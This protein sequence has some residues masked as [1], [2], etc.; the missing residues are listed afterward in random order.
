M[1]PEDTLSRR[2]ERLRFPDEPPM[3]SDPADDLRRGTQLLRRRRAMVLVPALAAVTAAVTSVG[4]ALL[5]GDA[6]RDVQVASKPPKSEPYETASP[7]PEVP[8]PPI[9]PAPPVS[10]LSPREQAEALE[11]C[12]KGTPWQGFEPTLGVRFHEEH[13]LDNTFVVAKRG[14]DKLACARHGAGLFGNA[15][16]KDTPK[17]QG[18]LDELQNGMGRYVQPIA[19]VTVQP[20]N[21]AEQEA[22]LRDGYWFLPMDDSAD[23][24]PEAMDK[25][26]GK[27]ANRDPEAL[28]KLL[29]RYTTQYKIRGYDANGKLVATF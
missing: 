11:A 1:R 7:R 22:V 27:R 26:M 15:A 12:T 24:P 13:E 23:I 16:A 20:E 28:N 29:Q 19:K 3:A 9:R 18:G 14:D 25:V 2:F 21:G 10:D 6:E 5:P 8:K 4:L 17:P